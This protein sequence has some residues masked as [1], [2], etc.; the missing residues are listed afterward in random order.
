MLLAVFVP[1]LMM[2]GLTGRLYQQFALTISIASASGIVVVETAGNGGED[3]DHSA[4]GGAFDR[5]V[6]DSGAL[7]VGAGFIGLEMAENLVKR[8]V[9]TIILEMPI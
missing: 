1:T 3:L 4:F 5:S 7:I 2:P 8:G 9:N 6:R